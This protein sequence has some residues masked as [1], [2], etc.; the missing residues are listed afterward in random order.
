M[1]NTALLLL[2]FVLCTS[3]SYV[4][5]AKKV[6]CCEQKAA[7]CHD[8]MC[9]LPRYAHAAGVDPKAFTPETP[10]YASAE[11]LQPPPG[12]VTGK[13]SWLSR[14]NPYPWLTEEREAAAAKRRRENPQ[15]SASKEEENESFWGRLWPF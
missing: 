2:S 13:P 4:T 9:C 14:L 1:K 6:D 3:C 5:P 11:D 12:S 8:Q 10:S 7:C 15:E